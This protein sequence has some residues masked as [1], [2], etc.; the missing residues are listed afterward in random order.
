M[1]GG[2]KIDMDHDLKIKAIEVIHKEVA[3]LF[4]SMF[5]VDV[6]V[7][8][9]NYDQLDDDTIVAKCAL[10]QSDVTF[11]L[12]FAFQRHVISPM[13]EKLY[14]DPVMAKHESSMEDAACEIS[15]IICSGLK[16]F[17]NKS[18]YELKIAIPEI[19][20][21][22]RS[23]EGQNSNCVGVYFIVQGNT[24]HIGIEENAQQGEI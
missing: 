23:T 24:F 21:N 19:D 17:L 22:F 2:E 15:N 7:C 20:L 14:G 18:G 6:E 3:A 9:N 12:R 16:T 8:S 1:A 13:L 5:S 4:V 11:V 10:S